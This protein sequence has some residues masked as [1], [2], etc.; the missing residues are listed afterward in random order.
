ML[1]ETEDIAVI[2]AN[3]FKNAITVQKSVVEH[4]NPCVLCGHKL[5]IDIH[6]HDVSLLA[7]NAYSNHDPPALTGWSP[8][9]VRPCASGLAAA[10]DT[11]TLVHR[12]QK[13]RAV[14]AVAYGYAV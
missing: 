6:L 2:D 3:A 8:K 12:A 1:L 13:D 9:S 7:K 11:A 10:W 5:P 4:R 14:A